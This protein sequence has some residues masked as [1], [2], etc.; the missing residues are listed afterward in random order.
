[1][2]AKYT[3]GAVNPVSVFVDDALVVTRMVTRLRQATVAIRTAFPNGSIFFTLDGSEPSFETTLYRGPFVVR[4]SAI[5][6]VIAYDADFHQ[7]ARADP[8]EV[9]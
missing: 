5:V 8:V 2:W 6:R 3:E 9:I 7:S 1:L 4:R